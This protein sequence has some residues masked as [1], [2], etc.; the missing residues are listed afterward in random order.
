MIYCMSSDFSDL[1]DIT[2]GPPLITYTPTGRG[3]GSS[4][5]YISIAYYIQKVGK[6]VKKACQNAYV[7]NG[8][9]PGNSILPRRVPHRRFQCGFL[10]SD[11]QVIHNGRMGSGFPPT[12]GQIP[13][14]LLI[15]QIDTL[16]WRLHHGHI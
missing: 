6:G 2:G 1:P 8:R 11:T 5:L 13:P 9:P 4:L 14:A 15:G 3:G 16:M 10:G 12:S 7:I